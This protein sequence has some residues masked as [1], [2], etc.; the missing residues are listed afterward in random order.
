MLISSL[1]A[2]WIT[3]FVVLIYLFLSFSPANASFWCQD[4][5][6]SSHL[7]SS[8]IGK[9]WTN[10]PPDTDITQQAPVTTQTAVFSSG[11]G[12]D[13]L[14]SPVYTSVLTS[15]SRET[16]LNRIFETNFDTINLPR[17]PNLSVEVSRFTNPSLPAHLL[18]S[19][20]LKALRTVVLLH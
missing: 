4:E 17:I 14:D 3:R 11:Q 2:K 13:C 15:S 20:T 5:G 10:C 12:D 6:S 8:P 16:S 19:Q 7:E 18:V 1:H 9:C